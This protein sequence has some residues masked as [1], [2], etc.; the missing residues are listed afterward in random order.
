MPDV[1]FLVVF[2]LFSRFSHF[3]ILR[4]LGFNPQFVAQPV[5]KR[6]SSIMVAL[7]GCIF[8]EQFFMERF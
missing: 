1:L 3:L 4:S 2:V 7:K 6:D 8:F 5:R